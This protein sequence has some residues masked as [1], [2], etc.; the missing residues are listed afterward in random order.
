MNAMT[1]LR[2]CRAAE[3]EIGQIQQ[4]I[5]RRREILDGLSA[6]AAD[7]NGG[8]RGGGDPDKIGR[9]MAEVDEMEREIA[10]RREA[11]MAEKAASLALTE[12][13]PDTEGKVLYDYYVLRLDTPE[14]ARK[15]KYVAGYVRKV[16]RSGEQLLAMISPARVKSVLPEWYIREKGDGEP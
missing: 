12:M 11:W 3:N 5:D 1:V 9:V 2:R 4:R 14:I 15:E 8:S 6:P 10:A 16:K 13:V 7:P